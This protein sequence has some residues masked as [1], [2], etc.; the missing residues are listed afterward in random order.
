MSVISLGRSMLAEMHTAIRILGGISERDES[1]QLSAVR[2]LASGSSIR[3]LASDRLVLLELEVGIGTEVASPIKAL[4]SPAAAKSALA[5]ARKSGSARLAFGGGGAVSVDFDGRS[6]DITSSAKGG[7]PDTDRLW[8]TLG[9]ARAGLPASVSPSAA[10][11][12]SALAACRGV[13][14]TLETASL[15]GGSRIL[16]GQVD[17][18]LRGRFAASASAQAQQPD[19]LR[20]TGQPW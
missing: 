13:V 6:L 10:K 14:V 15:A 12:I 4:V 17:G 11:A 8:E 2:L 7:H 19:A 3:L 9:R 18:T 1:L 20:W 5:L 16:R